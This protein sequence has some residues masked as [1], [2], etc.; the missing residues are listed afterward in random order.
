M[1]PL[2]VVLPRRNL[3]TG[4]DNWLEIDWKAR[5]GLSSAGISMNQSSFLLQQMAKITVH[6]CFRK[7][8]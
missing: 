1:A 6:I 4:K 2:P 8:F 7:T 3:K 5:F